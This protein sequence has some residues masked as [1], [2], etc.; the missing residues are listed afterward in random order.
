MKSLTAKEL[1][2]ILATVPD[3]Q[4]VFIGEKHTEYEGHS[5]KSYTLYRYEDG[6]VQLTFFADE[7]CGMDF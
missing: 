2:A 3:D 1:R 5:I 4:P 7:N 6:S